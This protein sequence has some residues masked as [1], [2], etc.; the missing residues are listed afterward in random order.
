MR[1][2][3]ATV[4]ASL[5]ALTLATAPVSAHQFSHG[6]GHGLWG[7]AGVGFGIAAGV[8]GTGIAADAYCVRY[9]PIYDD[10]GNYVGQHPVSV[11]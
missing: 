3:T 11:C 8:I 2:L 7:G 10:T 1:A 9:V 5:A 4:L 6:G